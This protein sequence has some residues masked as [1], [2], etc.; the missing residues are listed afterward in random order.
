MNQSGRTFPTT[1]RSSHEHSAIVES[2]P[3]AHSMKYI[4]VPRWSTV[5]AWSLAL[6][7]QAVPSPRCSS[8]QGTWPI[9][10][11][12]PRCSWMSLRFMFPSRK[13]HTVDDDSYSTASLPKAMDR[14]RVSAAQRGGHM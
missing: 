8:S 13:Y 3:P 9:A 5:V 4:F 10:R 2:T 7:S 14:V 12:T 1:L 11:S 6:L